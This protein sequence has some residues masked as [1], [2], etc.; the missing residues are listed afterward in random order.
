[1]AALLLSTLAAGDSHAYFERILA[2]ARV[3]AT[4]GAYL[5]IADDATA[6][7]INPAGL[8]NLYSY[9]AVATFN[10]PYGVGDI[11]ESF[12]AAGMKTRLFAFGA[13][14][15]YRGVSGVASENLVTLSV[16]R[17]V[18]RTSE[19]ASLS[20]GA[21]VDLARVSVSDRFNASDGAATFGLS[22][23]LRPFPVVGVGY[24]VRN[25]NESTLH[26]LDGGVGT[27]LQRRQAWGLSY[28]WDK[29]LTVSLER[30][31][32]TLGEWRHHG[33]VEFVL[34][35]H[36]DL[37]SGVSGRNATAGVGFQLSGVTVDVSVAS[38]QELGASY[39]MTL[40]F[41][42][43]RPENPYAQ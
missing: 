20:V 36:V 4:G 38:H 25:L 18:A 10:R 2:S 24:T 13:A 34:H 33:G 30:R 42:N 11:T 8:T 29:R 19:D 17:D 40:G 21:H 28:Y 27:P 43:P 12:V 5:S 14:W 16:A 41:G 15:S 35:K 39:I 26:L 37:R 3:S 7:Y 32:D 9:H 31:Q 6:A 23:L 22:V 1:M